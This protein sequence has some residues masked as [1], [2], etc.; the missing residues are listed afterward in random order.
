MEFQSC[1]PIWEKL[2]ADQQRRILDSL[3]FRQVKTG[4]VIHNGSADC[5]G[6]RR[7]LPAAR[8]WRP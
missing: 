6:A 2:T 5:S 7:K 1:F 3:A 4:T 8:D